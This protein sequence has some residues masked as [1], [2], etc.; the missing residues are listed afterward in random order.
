MFRCRHDFAKDGMIA[1]TH[2]GIRVGGQAIVREKRVRE[3]GMREGECE[4][5]EFF[6]A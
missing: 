4:K 5:Y 1:L 6:N 2:C 3:R